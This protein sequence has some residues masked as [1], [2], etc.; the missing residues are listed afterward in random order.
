MQCITIP[1]SAENNLPLTDHCIGYGSL[2]KHIASSVKEVACV[3][4]S[5]PRQNQVVLVE[6]AGRIS[7]WSTAATTLARRKNQADDA[8]HLVYLPEVHF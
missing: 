2:A 1:A 3:C 4:E 8:P 7:G 6:V 5:L